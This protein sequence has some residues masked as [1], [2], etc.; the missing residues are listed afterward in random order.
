MFHNYGKK[1]SKNHYLWDILTNKLRAAR[2]ELDYGEVRIK[3][4]F[5]ITG[6]IKDAIEVHSVSLCKKMIEKKDQSTGFEDFLLPS[7]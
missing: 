7:R 3:L 4:L 5:E 1:F 6:C 2:H